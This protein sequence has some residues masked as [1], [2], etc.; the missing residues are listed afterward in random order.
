MTQSQRKRMM[1]KRRQAILKKRAMHNA[2]FNGIMIM[3]TMLIGLCITVNSNQNMQPKVNESK[4]SIDYH[5]TAGVASILE[6]DIN[7]SSSSSSIEEVESTETYPQFK[8]SKDWD[9]NDSY[10]LAKIAM[11]E[12]GNQNIQTKTLVIMTILNRVRDEYFPNTIEEV[13][14]QQGSNGVYQ[15][16]PIG[17]GSWEKNK[18]DEDCWE[19]VKIVME[20]KYDYS[21]GALYFESC[22]NEDNWHSRNLEFLYQSQA[23]RFYK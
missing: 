6:K 2:I 3:F 1:I 19:A 22:E 14:F 20:S 16:S 5:L 15:F 11:C 13:I 7:Q 12:A 10:L 8:Y 23:M 18:P 21:G 4:T 9:A 17:D